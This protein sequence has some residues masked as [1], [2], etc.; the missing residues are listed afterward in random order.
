MD[1]IRKYTEIS[2]IKI[3]DVLQMNPDMKETLLI[4]VIGV[5]RMQEMKA[6]MP[7]VTGA[8]KMVVLG[9]LV[10]Y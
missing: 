10:Q 7:S 1:D 4:A 5:A 8:E 3:T 6:N 9:D 2:D